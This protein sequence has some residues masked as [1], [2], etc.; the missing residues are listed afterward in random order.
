MEIEYKQL[1]KHLAK[2]EMI[3]AQQKKV[4]EALKHRMGR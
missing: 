1:Q 3:R 2:S 4:I